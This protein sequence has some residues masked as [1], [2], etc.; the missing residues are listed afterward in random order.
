[1]K[2]KLLNLLMVFVFAVVVNIP[3]RIS[4][5]GTYPTPPPPFSLCN[6]K[7]RIQHC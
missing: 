5:G 6:S 2:N 4:N 3:S 1:M 7:L